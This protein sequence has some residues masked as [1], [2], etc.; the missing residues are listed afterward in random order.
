LPT[1]L[2]TWSGCLSDFHA[3]PPCCLPLTCCLLLER[4]MLVFL[5]TSTLML[6]SSQQP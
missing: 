2:L 4:S 5:S 6:T 1:E 3:V